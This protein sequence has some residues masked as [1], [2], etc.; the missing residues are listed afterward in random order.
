MGSLFWSFSTDPEKQAAS[1]VA[2]MIAHFN[3]TGEK[4]QRPP[5][6]KQEPQEIPVDTDM[7]DEDLTQFMREKPH[8]QKRVA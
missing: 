3:I 8:H 1:Q 6:P 5:E 2:L 4:L 7:E